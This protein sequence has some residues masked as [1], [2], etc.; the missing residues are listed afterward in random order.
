MASELVPPNA[1]LTRRA[2]F[3]RMWM[4]GLSARHISRKTGSSVT[5]VYR[6]IHRWQ[7]EGNVNTKLRRRKPRLLLRENAT[8]VSTVTPQFFTT[9]VDDVRYQYTGWKPPEG[10]D[11]LLRSKANFK[12]PYTDSLKMLTIIDDLRLHSNIWLPTQ[13]PL[14]VRY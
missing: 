12:P 4:D 1:V 3:V 2:M 11:P 6:W 10:F 7:Q 5:T 8:P 9:S 14:P 13:V